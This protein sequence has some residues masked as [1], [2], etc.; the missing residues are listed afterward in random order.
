M[1]ILYIITQADGGGAQKYVLDMAEHFG[2]AIAAGTE[3]GQL[4]DEAKK[5]GIKTFPLR[6]LKRN[7]SPWHDVLAIFEIKNLIKKER[8]DIVH[9]NSSKAG[10]LGSLAGKLAGAKVVFTAHGFFYF[11]NAAWYIKWPYT[12][13]EKFASKFRG[14]IITVSEQDRQQALAHHLL[15]P[16]K[17]ITIHNGIPAIPFLEAA[18]ARQALKLPEHKFILG[19]VAQLY[20]RKAINVLILAVAL[21]PTNVRAKVH[22]V[23]IGEGPERA[24]LELQL[25]NT[26]LGGI[27]TL[28][29]Y[30]PRA[31]TLLKA[32]NAFVLSSCREGFPYV[33]LE[34][35]QAGLPIVATDVGGNKEAL[36]DA[37]III[38]AKNPAALAK[39]IE[40]LIN[41]PAEQKELSQRALK[42]CQ[43][44]TL[45]KM[46]DKTEAVYREM[47]T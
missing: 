21:L 20:N 30:Q 6:H 29:G 37:G 16:E 12:F 45:E 18:A 43:E 2:G 19:N 32:F 8:P 7:V 24:N 36:G 15:P 46:F 42:R 27:F 14:A 4:F 9:L 5:R 22:A 47:G 23:V 1:D 41:N 11:K 17:I 40:D 34:A 44:F 31:V 13:L 10:F 38:P 35:M 33:L 28:A 26:G 25:K 3:A 39:T